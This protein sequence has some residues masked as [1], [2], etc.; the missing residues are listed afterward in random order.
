VDT[1]IA[2]SARWAGDGELLELEVKC[3]ACGKVMDTWLTPWR[4][5]DV[6]PQSLWTRWPC[7]PCE[8]ELQAKGLLGS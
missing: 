4:V 2:E 7:A 6:S 3:C 5:E 1:V 8:L